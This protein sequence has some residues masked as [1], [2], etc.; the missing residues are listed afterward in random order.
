MDARY[1]ATKEWCGETTPKWIARFCGDWL[2]KG[3]RKVDAV[4]I[5][6]AHSD[7]RERNLG[8]SAGQLAYEADTAIERTYH[9][10]TPR[11]TWA[12]LDEVARQSWERNPTV[13]AKSV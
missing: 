1:T 13:R 10:K 3:D 12:Q 4:M 5:C 2:G 6:L 11:R 8:K 7:E 9:D